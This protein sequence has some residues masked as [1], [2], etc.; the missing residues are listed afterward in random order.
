MHRILIVSIFADRDGEVD[1]VDYISNKHSDVIQWFAERNH[2]IKTHRVMDPVRFGWVYNFTAEDV[3]QEV[4][5][6]YQLTWK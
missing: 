6:E 3:S 1:V 2:T 4:Y 5:L